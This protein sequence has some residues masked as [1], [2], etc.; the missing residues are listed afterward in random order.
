[1]SINLY[2]PQSKSYNTILLSFLV[3]VVVGSFF[4]SIK[5]V[6]LR[7]TGIKAEGTVM[8]G[9]SYTTSYGRIIP[10]SF[11]DEQGTTH[12]FT[13]FCTQ[14]RY[15]CISPYYRTGEKVIVYYNKNDTGDVV[16]WSSFKIVMFLLTS[17][18]PLTIV[19]VCF[20]FFRKMLNKNKKFVV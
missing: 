19:F 15:G 20:I 3:L 1:M 11:I 5:P 10:V 13:E 2:N 7:V 18:A 16:I 6:V 17:I 14:N 8:E 9:Y 12:T 4:V